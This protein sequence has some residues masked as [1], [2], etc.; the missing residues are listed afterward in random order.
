MRG[1]VDGIMRMV[2]I[3]VGLEDDELNILVRNIHDYY[4]NAWRLLSRGNSASVG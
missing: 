1:V 4:K 2:Y 3:P